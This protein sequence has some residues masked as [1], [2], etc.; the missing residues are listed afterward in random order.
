MKRIRLDKMHYNQE[1]MVVSIDPDVRGKL[2]SMGL[3]TGKKTRMI[4]KEP[5]K[6]PVVLLVDQAN[7]SLGMGIAGKVQVEVDE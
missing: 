7:I 3:R 2:A 1:G 6:G 4:T 5:W